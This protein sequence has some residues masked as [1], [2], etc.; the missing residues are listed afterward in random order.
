MHKHAISIDGT[1]LDW[2]EEIIPCA[3]K[4]WAGTEIACEHISFAV[5]ADTY[6]NTQGEYI[7]L[8]FCDSKVNVYSQIL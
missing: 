8:L 6:L 3:G 5:Q 4:I 1:P 7:I 2:L